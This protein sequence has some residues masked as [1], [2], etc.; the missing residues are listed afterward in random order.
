MRSHDLP[1]TFVPSPK[2]REMLAQVFVHEPITL[3]QG[4]IRSGKTYVTVLTF[5]MWVL[6]ETPKD[7]DFIVASQRFSSLRRNVLTPMFQFLRMMGVAHEYKR[8]EQEVHIGGRR[9]FLVGAANERAQ[10]IIQGITAYGCLIDE[11]V[12][13][14]KSFFFQCLGRM[15][16]DASKMFCTYNP[17][18]P[19]H[20]FKREVVDKMNPV[21]F[22]FLLDDNPALG[23]ETKAR[24]RRMFTGAM[25][26]RMVGG[27]WAAASGVIYP[28]YTIKAPPKNIA[29]TQNDLAIDYGTSSVTAG[30]LIQRHRGVSYVTKEFYHDARGDEGKQLTD[31]S[32]VKQLEHFVSGTT[33]STIWVDPTASSLKVSLRRSGHKVR[34]AKNEVLDGLRVVGSLMEQEKVI[35]HPRCV[36]LLTELA[37]Y[38]WDEKQQEKGIDAPTKENDHACDALRY[39]VYSRA[40]IGNQRVQIKPQGL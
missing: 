10:D 24:Y 4:A 22:K 15:S 11:V 39:G 3:A 21:L 20:W 40:P 31:V 14:P 27:E 9:F 26:A 34:D 25:L 6:L 37:G 32:L 13:T 18:S 36:N 19:Y 7:A 16:F 35:I 29:F 2:Q 28:E 12:L 1:K 5:L 8:T 38:V 17:A 30:L 23:E 33:I